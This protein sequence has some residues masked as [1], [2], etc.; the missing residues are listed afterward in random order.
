LAN[1]TPTGT[2]QYFAK[3]YKLSQIRNAT[4]QAI[5]ID[6]DTVVSGFGNGGNAIWFRVDSSTVSGTVGASYHWTGQTGTYQFHGKPTGGG[7]YV[8][9][10]V[11]YP[12][13]SGQVNVAYAD[14]SVRPTPFSINGSPV[15]F[16]G[17]DY[18]IMDPNHPTAKW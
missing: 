14:G 4:R 5:F 1:E 2:G 12:V 18:L 7:T 10:G 11:T 6:T 9:G 15:K 17:D 13:R 8:A 16:Q 3:P